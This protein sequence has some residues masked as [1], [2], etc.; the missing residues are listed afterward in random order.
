MESG[1]LVPDD[2]ML[3]IVEEELRRQSGGVCLDGFPRTVDQ[4]R[5][6]TRILEGRGKDVD[7]A[8]FLET[9]DDVVIRRLTSR[10]VCA[11]CG[12]IFNVLTMP[13]KVEGICDRCSGP[14]EIRPDDREETVRRRLEVFKTRT[15]P[16]LEYYRGIG[17]LEVLNGA[18]DREI[19]QEELKGLVEAL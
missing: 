5:G 16:V 14:L 2:V 10:R 19:V 13:P 4:A 9:P 1:G 12:A 6:L 8:V 7:L 11:R 18:R 15:E 3:G 17:V